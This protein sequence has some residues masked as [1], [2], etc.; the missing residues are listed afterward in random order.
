M[1]GTR[2]QNEKCRKSA[3]FLTGS[4]AFA[5][6]TTLKNVEVELRNAPDTPQIS[7]LS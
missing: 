6:Q 7:N 5:I 3:A 1:S 4:V 2:N